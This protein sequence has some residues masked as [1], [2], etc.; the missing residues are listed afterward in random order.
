LAQTIERRIRNRNDCTH[1]GHWLQEFYRQLLKRHIPKLITRSSLLRDFITHHNQPLLPKKISPLDHGVFCSF[2]DHFA[3]SQTLEASKYQIRQ[4]PPVN[5]EF[6]Q[7]PRWTLQS[8]HDPQQSL[9]QREAQNFIV[10]APFIQW[11]QFRHW[12]VSHMSEIVCPTPKLPQRFVMASPVGSGSDPFHVSQDICSLYG[13]CPNVPHKLGHRFQA[14]PIIDERSHRAALRFLS[15]HKFFHLFLDRQISVFDNFLF[16]KALPRLQQQLGLVF[17]GLSNNPKDVL[18]FDRKFGKFNRTA[19]LCLEY[20]FL[21]LLFRFKESAAIFPLFRQPCR[22]PDPIEFRALY[23]L[24]STHPNLL[25]FVAV[26]QGFR[27]RFVLFG[28]FF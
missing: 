3:R 7:D 20:E 24:A 9:K 8:L 23:H 26:F 5:S 12:I 15:R 25:L 16:L 4:K 2:S 10:H 11:L 27:G 13:A 21:P 22:N 1:P 19:A 6:L 28:L 17:R 14:G 18:F